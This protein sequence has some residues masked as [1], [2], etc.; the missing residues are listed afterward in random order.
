MSSSVVFS[1]YFSQL[2]ITVYSLKSGNLFPLSLVGVLWSLS[3]L[4]VLKTAKTTLET[5]VNPRK[6]T[7]ETSVNPRKAT[8]ETSVVSN[9]FCDLSSFTNCS[10]VLTSSHSHILTHF[11]FVKK[12]SLFDVSNSI[13]GLIF[14]IVLPFLNLKIQK[15]SVVLCVVFCLYLCWVMLFVL[16]KFCVV[17]FGCYLIVFA[18]A[19]V[20]FNMRRK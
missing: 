19:W 9:T 5:S 13:F 4:N 18:Q 6:A 16:R 3:A 10:D 7:L 20:I 14:F 15:V 8:L 2:S 1:L 11:N 17:C 12:G